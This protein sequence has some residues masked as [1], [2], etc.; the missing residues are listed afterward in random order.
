MNA[1]NQHEIVV[2]K[3]NENI[4][5]NRK[6]WFCADIKKSKHYTLSNFGE[7]HT[8]KDRRK[9]IPMNE[10]EYYEKYSIVEWETK[11]CVRC[12]DFKKG[13]WMQRKS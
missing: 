11:L 1:T 12:L 4:Q 5:A 13:K 10:V 7:C 2:N 6:L 3:Q 8:T 9:K